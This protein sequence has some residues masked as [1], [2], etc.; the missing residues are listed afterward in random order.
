[1][2]YKK[3]S[4]PS[5]KAGADLVYFTVFVENCLRGHVWRLNFA[6]NWGKITF[7]RKE[8]LLYNTSCRAHL[9]CKN[10]LKIRKKAGV[11][12]GDFYWRNWTDLVAASYV[13]AEP[14]GWLLP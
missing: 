8:R 3:R 5:Q 9:F 13:L 10:E 12:S 11:N 14:P 2:N 6:D 1:M 7:S 4:V